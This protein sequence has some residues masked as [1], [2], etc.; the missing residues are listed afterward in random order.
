MV[1][2]QRYPEGMRIIVCGDRLPLDSEVLGRTGTVIQHDRNIPDRYAVQLDGESDLKR[3]AEAE[4]M[5]MPEPRGAEVPAS[6][7]Q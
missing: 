2:V 6:R 4:L 7:D 1:R 5:P 3:F